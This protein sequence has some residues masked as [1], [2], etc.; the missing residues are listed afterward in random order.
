MEKHKKTDKTFLHQ[1]RFIKTQKFQ[2][3]RTKR[4]GKIKSKYKSKNCK[5]KTKKW[6]NIKYYFTNI[7]KEIATP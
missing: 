7:P 4:N 2:K 5:S 1:S 3:R 6:K